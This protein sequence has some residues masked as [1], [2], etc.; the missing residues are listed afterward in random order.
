MA[1]NPTRTPK[2]HIAKDGTQSWKVRYRSG[3][4]TEKSETFYDEPSAVEFAG[5]LRALGPAKAIEY[6]DAREKAEGGKDAL[7]F[8]EVWHRWSA[9]KFALREDGTP[10]R[11]R[12]TRTIKDYQRM[13]RLRIKPRFGDRPANIIAP[14]DVQVW[15]DELGAELDPKTVHD[16]HALLHAVFLWAKQPS[17]ALVIGDP[18][19]E[20]DLPKKRR[21]GAK[22]LRPDQWAILYG[23]AQQVDPDAAD[24]LLFLVASQ[25]RWS[26]AARVPVFAVD[27]WSDETGETFT[28]VTMGRILRREASG[29]VVVEDSK[30]DAGKRSVRIRGM[31]EAMVLRRIAGKAPDDMIFTTGRGGKWDYAHFHQRVWARPKNPK[32]DEA[33]NR[34][35][36]LEVAAENGFTQLDVTFHW[37]RHTG[38]AMLLLAGEPMAAVSRRLGHASIKTTVDVYGRMIDDTSAAGLDRMDAMLGGVPARVI[39]APHEAE[40]IEYS[41]LAENYDAADE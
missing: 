40:A 4:G 39:P 32:W 7:T 12:S 1:R 20:T 35:R 19:E 34:K 9:W 28:Y 38:A 41:G 31:A 5:L 16:Y 2:L 22:G 3:T 29:Y 25:W 36:I 13:Y 11:V 18:C 37:L 30:S 24:L 15:I 21:K 6:I 14:Q 10:I 27:H 33:P 23:A 17:R 8:D 26:E